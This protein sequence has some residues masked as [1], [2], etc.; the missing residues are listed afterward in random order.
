MDFSKEVYKKAFELAVD[1]YVSRADS[2]ENECAKYAA[3]QA[4]LS[5]EQN[6][7]KEFL[8]QAIKELS[9]T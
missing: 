4:N 7:Q 3:K 5:I 8:E 6:E 9:T 1:A 2:W